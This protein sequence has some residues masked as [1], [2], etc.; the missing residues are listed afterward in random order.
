[1][2]LGAHGTEL[3]AR[4]RLSHLRPG[5]RLSGSNVGL[6]IFLLI[7]S[8]EYPSLKEKSLSVNDRTWAILEQIFFCTY[9]CYL[10]KLKSDV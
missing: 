9:R 5:G 10:I 2:P 4:G 1:M 8:V 3:V 7:C 6:P